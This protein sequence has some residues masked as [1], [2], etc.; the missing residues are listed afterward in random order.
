MN[1]CIWQVDCLDSFIVVWFGGNINMGIIFQTLRY[2]LL[3]LLN[4]CIKVYEFEQSNV[5]SR[6]GWPVRSE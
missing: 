4:Y 6:S 1:V 2:L 5:Y 3:L